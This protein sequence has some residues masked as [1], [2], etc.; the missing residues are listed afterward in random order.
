MRKDGW[1]RVEV[2][3]EYRVAHIAFHKFF[4]FVSSEMCTFDTTEYYDDILKALAGS[5]W[6][7]S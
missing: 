2:I 6:H 4:T 1:I 7:L 3:Q 5:L